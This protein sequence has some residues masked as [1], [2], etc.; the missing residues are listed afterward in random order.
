MKPLKSMKPLKP[1]KP[2]SLAIGMAVL[3]LHVSGA[4]AGKPYAGAGVVEL[5]G[6]VLLSFS[7]QSLT[8]EGTD[9]SIDVSATDVALQPI[10]GYFVAPRLQIFGGP[11][12]SW[13]KTSPDGADATTTTSYGL[14]A[15]AGYYV[16]AGAVF[17][18]PRAQVSFVHLHLDLGGIEGNGDGW[19]FQGGGALRVPFGFGGLLEVAALVDYLTVSQTVE[20][21]GMEVNGSNTGLSFGVSLGFFAYF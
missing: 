17:L 8:P 7:S 18:G 13:A 1:M 9:Q 2:A 20:G 12:F 4:A 5:G 10:I 6:S 14:A 11:L 21:F 16:P 19:D 3:G 15:G